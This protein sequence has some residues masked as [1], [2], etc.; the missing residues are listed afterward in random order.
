MDDGPGE[1]SAEGDDGVANED[2]NAE[3]G[4][5]GLKRVRLSH[6]SEPHTEKTGIS[7]QMVQKPCP[8]CLYGSALWLNTMRDRRSIQVDQ[9]FC[10]RGYAEAALHQVLCAIYAPSQRCLYAVR[11]VTKELGTQRYFMDATKECV[12]WGGRIERPASVDS[13]KHIPKKYPSHPHPC[14][15]CNGIGDSKWFNLVYHRLHH[16]G[17]HLRLERIEETPSHRH[18]PAG[19]WDISPIP[20]AR[21]S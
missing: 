20:N 4:R 19:P 11:R 6:D 9:T 1:S 14:P 13:M 15:L 5:A 7:P 8:H 2:E 21:A 18:H 10:E 16:M 3:E 17:T 12:R